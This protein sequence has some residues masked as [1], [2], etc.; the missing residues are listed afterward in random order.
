MCAFPPVELISA[1][2]LI[3]FRITGSPAPVTAADADLER[4]MCPF[5][6]SCFDLALQHHFDFLHGIIWPHSCDNVQKTYDIWKHY[7]APPFFHYLDVPHMTGPSSFEFFAGELQNLK[8]ALEHFT[9]A[10]ITSAKLKHALASHNQTRALL[11][12][13]SGLRRPDPPRLRGSEMLT[14][15]LAATALPVQEANE[16]LQAALAEARA[17]GQVTRPGAARLLLYGS[18]VDHVGL[19]QLLEDAGASVVI[20]DLCLGS[21]LFLHDVPDDGDPLEALARY[22]L[23]RITCPRTFRSAPD[24]GRSLEPRFGHLRGMVR[25]YG[26]QAAVIY[27]LMFCDTFEFDA[28]DVKEYLEGVGV[29]SL[30]LED[31][32]RLSG[33][34]GFRTRIEAF[35]EM[36]SR[37]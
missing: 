30:H 27:V 36:I 37:R 17:R 33:A 2:G 18:E 15:M 6:R 12:E 14:L 20:E 13:L 32:Y 31:D 10:E 28:P 11:R 1:A 22:Y 26:V 29:P 4:L 24:H 35:L 34:A 5:I 3:P 7:A 19:L 16:L 9:G 25:D 23:D 8:T 21:K